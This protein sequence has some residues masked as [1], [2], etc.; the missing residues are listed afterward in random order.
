MVVR[1]RFRTGPKIARKRGKNKRIALAVA[2]LLPPAALCA[3]VLG[4]WRIGAMQILPGLEYLPHRPQIGAAQAGAAWQA[5]TIA[6][7]AF[8][9]LVARDRQWTKSSQGVE[10]GSLPRADSLCANVVAIAQFSK[11]E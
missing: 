10:L 5:H 2:A 11:S 6:P 8:V 3:G 1:I 9:N 7:M 4:L